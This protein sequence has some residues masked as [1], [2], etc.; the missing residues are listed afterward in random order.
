MTT[1]EALA[2]LKEARTGAMSEVID[3]MRQ[4]E[5]D[6]AESR[7]ATESVQAA[8]EEER[9][10]LRAELARRAD[11]I[12]DLKVTSNH[13]LT[14]LREHAATVVEAIR[15]LR[16]LTA[17]IEQCDRCGW[18]TASRSVLNKIIIET[19]EFIRQHSI[20]F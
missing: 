7:K 6:L 13:R 18:D 1:E 17:A 9:R 5:R 3:R 14:S 8:A 11:T 12:V 16:R 2:A 10:T 15:A 4:L 19:A 20:P